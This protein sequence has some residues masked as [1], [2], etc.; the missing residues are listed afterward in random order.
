MKAIRLEIYQQTA[1]YRI[2]NSCFFRESYPL[3]PYSTVIGM[4]H[5]LCGYTEYHPMYVSVQG[6]FASTTSD[7]FTRYEFGNSKFDEKRHQ[8]NVGGY[9]VCR[10]IGNT[11][12]L[13]DVNLLIH[14]IPQNQEEIGKRYES[15]S[16]PKEYPSLGRREDLALFKDV[17]IVEVR[18]MSDDDALPE[19]VDCMSAYIPL[20]LDNSIMGIDGEIKQSKM[21]A[22]RYKDL[23][24]G[25]E[26]NINKDYTLHEMQRG[27]FE[28]MWNKVKVTY[29]SD[30]KVKWG[31]VFIDADNN[32]PIFPA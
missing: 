24:K 16:N 10:G 5:N 27:R 23:V 14:I 21:V 7:L 9:G 2:P 30:Y 1:N 4:I 19:R 18:K 25:T 13:V 6:S 8:F 20:V 31:N 26:Y 3:P 28:R 32:C 22:L 29:V 11:Q 15:L 12:L 17:E